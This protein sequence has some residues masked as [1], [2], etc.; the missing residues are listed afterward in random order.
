MPF[1]LFP[2]IRRAF[3]S[4]VDISAETLPP[5]F[6]EFVNADDFRTLGPDTQLDLVDT[7][8]FQK[9]PSYLAL[10]RQQ[11]ADKTARLLSQATR[12]QNLPEQAAFAFGAPAA[13]MAPPPFNVPAALAFGTLGSLG[14]RATQVLERGVPLSEALSPRR[15]LPDVQRA[16]TSGSLQG[17]VE[18]AG[19]IAKRVGDVTGITKLVE[20]AIGTTA[21]KVGGKLFVPDVLSAEARQ[22]GR[23]LRSVGGPSLTLGQRTDQA[24]K[25]VVDVMETVAFGSLT[26]R[27]VNATRGLQQTK[28]N[29]A[30]SQLA[31]KFREQA[32]SVTEVGQAFL[33]TVTG[34]DKVFVRRL[35]DTAFD[36][37]RQAVPGRVVNSIDTLK[38]LRS[39]QSKLGDVVIAELRN[40][41][42]MAPEAIDD[43]IKLL[44]TPKNVT[45]ALPRLTVDQ[46][47][48]L[49]SAL[50]RISVKPTTDVSAQQLFKSA[51]LMERRVNT[52]IRQALRGR[53]V[54]NETGGIGAPDAE[55]LFDRTNAF[56]T[57]GFATFRNTLA[58]S[59]LKQLEKTPSAIVNLLTGGDK[60]LDTIR[61]ARA[62]VGDQFWK[63]RVQP[64]FAAGVL[65]D[66]AHPVTGVIS[67]D[68][69]AAALKPFGDD[70]LAQVFSPGQLRGLR[71]MAGSISLVSVPPRGPGGVLIQL[72]QAGAFT[73]IGG[74]GISTAKDF[75]VGDE[76][77]S[78]VRNRTVLTAGLILVTPTLLGRITADPRLV[79]AFTKGV[80]QFAKGDPAPLRQTLTIASRQLAA[81]TAANAASDLQEQLAGSV[82][83]FSLPTA[84]QSL[85][86]PSFD[87]LRRQIPGFG[88]LR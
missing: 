55:A 83:E 21:K 72:V 36:S 88:T 27:I 54:I 40:S 82:E 56:A 70:V 9:D 77:D 17:I 86:I 22:T 7:F 18:G 63:A 85:Q 67:A 79:Q 64:A 59:F 84:M 75:F 37:I 78:P 68:G 30:A 29:Q 71:N 51:G 13:L 5:R 25:R 66:A 58:K 19:P 52:D 47:I 57:Q 42:E 50:G 2:D 11:R 34:R 26:S 10:D 73:A 16:F 65:E 8:L 20:K 38:L 60:K 39:K 15:L 14:G 23:L 12:G 53:P 32:G 48:R 76:S 49:K 74:A 33:A 44:E 35:M 6:E 61:A 31:S 28:L 81:V 1:H 41:R 46:A 69:I 62:A 80:F 43:L 24:L 3:T 87:Q 4:D 45:L